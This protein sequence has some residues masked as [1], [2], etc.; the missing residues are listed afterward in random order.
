MV[1]N[2]DAVKKE[3]AQGIRHAVLYVYTGLFRNGHLC[4]VYLYSFLLRACL[5]GVRLRDGMSEVAGVNKDRGDVELT[6]FGV[7]PAENNE[8]DD[9]TVNDAFQPEDS[10]PVSSPEQRTVVSQSSP[11]VN[12]TRKP[13]YRQENRAMPRSV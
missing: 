2:L 3:I 1:Q 9:G 4:Y 10:S 11:Q 8:T 7:L 12:L 6:N 5:E 13:C